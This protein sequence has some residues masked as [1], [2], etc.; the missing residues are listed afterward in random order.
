MHISYEKLWKLLIE[1]GLQK[2]DLLSLCGISSRT[3]SKLSKNQNVN[4]DTLLAVCGTLNCE[5]NDIME[6]CRESAPRSLYD[7]FCACKAVSSDI[8][9]D[10]YEFE[11]GGRRVIVKKTRERAG[12][13]T[14]IR[15]SEN[16]L[17]WTDVVPLG[18]MHA[19]NAEHVICNASFWRE[20]ALCIVVISGRNMGFRNLDD[21]IFISWNRTPP[22][23]KH[24]YLMSEPR[25]KLFEAK[26]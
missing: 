18:M 7:A 19:Q 8:Y 3:L 2:T 14:F 23:G 12:K 1:R 6:I 22:D 5:L 26:I 13:T 24:I 4:T 16:S 9:T 25:F 10:T 17:V 21:G 20:G 15:C 11:F